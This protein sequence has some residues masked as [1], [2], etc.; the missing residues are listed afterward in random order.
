MRPQLFSY[1][2]RRMIFLDARTGKGYRQD[3]KD[4]S[5]IIDSRRKTPTLNDLLNTAYRAAEAMGGDGDVWVMLTG[6]RH[7]RKEGQD[8]FFQEETKE[9][10]HGTHWLG[11]EPTGN[12]TN[13]LTGAKVRISYAV[14]WFSSDTLSAKDA[15]YAW[16]LLTSLLAD[17]SKGQLTVPMDTPGAT[18]ARLWALSLSSKADLEVPS[19][20]VAELIHSTA[21]QHHI[22]HLVAGPNFTNHPDCIPLV[23]P[24]KTP[25]IEKFAYIDG[26]FMYASVTREIGVG[27][28]KQLTRSE[29]ADLFSQNQFARARYKVTFTVPGH[30]EHIGLFGIQDED[31]YDW[32]WPNRP[33]ATGTTW[34]DAAELQIASAMGWGID[35]HEAMHFT[36]KADPLRT[37]SERIVRARTKVAEVKGQGR[38]PEAALDAVEDALRNVLL[39]SIGRFA[40]RGRKVS[41]TV[42]SLQDL[43]PGVSERDAHR[44]KDDTYTYTAYELQSERSERDLS[45]YHPEISAQIWGRS[46]ARL[47]IGPSALGNDTSGVLTMDP[48]TIIGVQGDAV[49]ATTVPDYARPTPGGD[50]GRVGRLRLKGVLN[51]PIKTPSTLKQRDALRDK[52]QRAGIGNLEEA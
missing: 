40:S 9:W 33:G 6:K 45:Y 25:Q 2:S 23:D 19:P 30:W 36:G 47:L 17:V 32:I 13:A 11:D 20:E 48:S 34:V 18:G 26:R 46:R 7:T 31:S 49:F 29:A 51:G 22:D 5:V 16:W 21:G 8:H 42:N 12:Y 15:G 4:V 37:Y 28:I 41:H 50:D 52:A 10:D 1:K 3:A 27:P 39:H 38:H 14:S 24:A 44:G 43:P 35:F